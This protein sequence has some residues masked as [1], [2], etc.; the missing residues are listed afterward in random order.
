MALRAGQADAETGHHLVEHEQ[1]AV[2]RAQLAD[3]LDERHAGAHEVHVAGDRFDDHAGDCGAVLG[4]RCLDL[5]DVVVFQDQGVL[6]HL[7]R[8]AGA[9]RVAEG[10]QARAGLDQQ[11]VGV[12]VVAT[13]ELDDCLAAGGAA[14][15]PDGAHAGLGARADQAHHLQTRAPAG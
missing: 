10:G 11:R 4:E 15:Q 12:T 8:H 1:R 3:A 14:R 2:L 5:R 6:H 9:G 7:G 13:L